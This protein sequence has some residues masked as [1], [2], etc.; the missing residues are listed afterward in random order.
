M[1]SVWKRNP[2][3]PR[4]AWYLTTST[5]GGPGQL[6]CSHPFDAIKVKLQRQPAQLPDQPPSTL[7]RLMFFCKSSRS[8]RHKGSSQRYAHPTCYCGSLR[9][10]TLLSKKTKGSIIKLGTWLSSHKSA[11]GLEHHV[12]GGQGTSYP[13]REC[14]GSQSFHRVQHSQQ[15]WDTVVVE[16]APLKECGRGDR[17]GASVEEVLVF[18]RQSFLMCCCTVCSF[19]IKIGFLVDNLH[20]IF[21]RANELESEECEDEG[22]RSKIS[23]PLAQSKDVLAEIVTNGCGLLYALTF[24]VMY[25]LLLKLGNVLR[26]GYRLPRQAGNRVL[27]VGQSKLAAEVAKK[28]P[29]PAPALALAGPRESVELFS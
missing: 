3:K 16:E 5:V 1:V 26:K 17:G 13:G 10:S 22:K 27:R 2:Q 6:I 29:D 24:L 7:E 20:L 23:R 19:P 21:N 11:A 15:I 25:V 4:E 18:C 12:A 28:T 14:G 8:W 9:Q